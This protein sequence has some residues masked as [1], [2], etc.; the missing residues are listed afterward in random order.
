M[1][2]ATDGSGNTTTKKGGCGIIIDEPIEDESI[3]DLIL[4]LVDQMKDHVDEEYLDKYEDVSN[5]INFHKDIMN[6]KRNIL[7]N[8]IRGLAMMEVAN[9]TIISRLNSDGREYSFPVPLGEAMD[10]TFDGQVHGFSGDKN[11]TNNRAE[12][13]AVIIA[14]KLLKGRKGVKIVTD[15]KYVICVTDPKFVKGLSDKG[16]REYKING[17]LISE[18]IKIKDDVEF[19]FVKVKAHRTKKE[20]LTLNAYELYLTNLN[21]KADDLAKAAM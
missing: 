9:E 6:L 5:I 14:L 17:D 10:I 11:P 20:K 21:E 7:Q 4:K 1:H 12:L 19:E 15:S 18:F 16:I 2:V 3:N 13:L 8:P